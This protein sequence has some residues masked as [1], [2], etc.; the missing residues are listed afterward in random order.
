[1]RAPNPEIFSI[2]PFTVYWYGVLIVTGATLAAWI[3]SRLSRRNGHDPE[4]AWNLLIVCLVTGIIGAR[5]YHVIDEWAYYRQNLAFRN[6]EIDILQHPFTIYIIPESNL[7]EHN[8]L[9][10]GMNLLCIFS[11]FDFFLIVQHFIDS[12]H[13][14]QTF[15][16]MI[17]S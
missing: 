10:E 6:A 15:L 13:G 11:L 4:I 14:C 2:G 17:I 8:F 12:V 9:I 7:I 1:M 5:L 16:D 3:A